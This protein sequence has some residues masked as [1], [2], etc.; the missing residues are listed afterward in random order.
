VGCDGINSQT[1]RSIMPDT[2][3]PA[4]TGVI[5]CG[6]FTHVPGIPPSD[7]VM[8]MTFGKRNVFGYQVTPSGEII[9]FQKA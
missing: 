6:G 4:Y 8:H 9:W 1:R 3:E 5:G 7:G 2:P